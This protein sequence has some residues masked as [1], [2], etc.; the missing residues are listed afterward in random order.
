[1]VSLQFQPGAMDRSKAFFHRFLVLL[2]GVAL[3]SQLALL[4]AR[5]NGLSIHSP[6]EVA[7]ADAIHGSLLERDSRLSRVSR[8]ERH[9]SD[10]GS[11]KLFA[12]ALDQ[13]MVQ[14]G[15][16]FICALNSRSYPPASTWTDTSA[17]LNHNE[18][19][20]STTVIANDEVIN[21]LQPWFSANGLSATLGEYTTIQTRN[22]GNKPGASGVS[23]Y[24]SYI[25]TPGIPFPLRTGRMHKV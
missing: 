8:V 14:Q 16:R 21:T 12:R 20:D 25:P 11:H 18:G 9:F 6:A 15:A 22:D 23:D 10:A 24:S 17:I 4:P 19:W 13:N 2:L 3:I 5:A 1:M 7:S